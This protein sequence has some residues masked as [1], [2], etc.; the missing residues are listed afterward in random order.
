MK[1]LHI[2]LTCLALIGPELGF[3]APLMQNARPK[4]DSTSV[5][6]L[7]S[8]IKPEPGKINLIADF[9]HKAGGDVDIYLINTTDTDV[10]FAS[11]DGDLG[12]KREAKT[13]MGKWMRCDSHGYSWCGNSYGSRPLKAGQFLSWTQA[14]DTKTGHARPLRF[15][16]Y[17]QGILEV[18]SN[19]GVGVVE[20]ADLEFCRFVSLAFECLG[21]DGPGV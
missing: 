19:E 2:I 18:V 14:A 12:C 7:P 9:D 5:A 3:A 6:N 1:L 8:H 11:Q 13:E 4:T 17:G 21:V 15:K 10:S 16:L 20:D